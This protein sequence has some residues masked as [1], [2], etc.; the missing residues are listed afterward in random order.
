MFLIIF[1][2]IE[3]GDIQSGEIEI[4]SV[5]QRFLFHQ[6]Q[7]CSTFSVTSVFSRMRAPTGSQGNT[8]LWALSAEDRGKSVCILDGERRLLEGTGEQCPVSWAGTFKQS[9]L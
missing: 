1:K 4:G 5:A 7:D 9:P 8:G 3:L 6:I 2:L